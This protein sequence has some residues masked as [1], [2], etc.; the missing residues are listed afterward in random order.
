[1]T[2]VKLL[3]LGAILQMLQFTNSK[4]SKLKISSQKYKKEFKN[5]AGISFKDGIDRLIKWNLDQIN[6]K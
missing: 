3:E 6:E 5:K 1:M 4:P 2:L